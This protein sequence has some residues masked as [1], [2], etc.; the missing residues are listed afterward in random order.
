MNIFNNLKEISRFFTYKGLKLF[1]LITLITVNKFF[2]VTLASSTSS[3]NS[4]HIDR[5]SDRLG[6]D[7]SAS[8][9]SGAIET[10]QS[11]SI[12]EIGE[13][14]INLNACEGIFSG[15]KIYIF[16]YYFALGLI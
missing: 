15:K 6:V 16:K 10:S 11:Q 7:N 3:A 14:V 5:K 12:V 4:N 1:S 8:I 13:N 9:S 2:I